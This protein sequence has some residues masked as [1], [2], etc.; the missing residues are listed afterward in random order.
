MT[1]IL[2]VEDEPDLYTG[3]R[4]VLKGRGYEVDVATRGDDGLK[5]AQSESYDLILLDV[6]L[7]GM[8]GFEVLRRLRDGGRVVP[9]APAAAAGELRFGTVTVDLSRYTIEGSSVSSL[10]TKAYEVLKVLLALQGQA[11]SRDTLID[12]V[13]GVDEFTSERTLNNLVV[14]IRHAIEPNPDDP[15]YL[16]TI[17]GI[18]YRL[19][20]R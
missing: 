20:V 16:K 6:G 1:R 12:R 14:K 11:V 5:Q 15:C 13:W 8:D 9:V 2:V 17:H 7:P 18:G 3:L 10:P 4:Q 19:D